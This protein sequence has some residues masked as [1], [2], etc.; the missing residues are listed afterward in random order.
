MRQGRQGIT[1]REPR[2]RVLVVDD[3][4]G[5]RSLL[6]S[7]LEAA[8]LDVVEADDGGRAVAAVN[9]SRPG[10]VILDVDLPGLSGYEVCHQLRA[11][12]ATL[13][14]LLLSGERVESYDRVAGLLLGADD[15]M[16]KPFAID[17]FLARARRMVAR[18]SGSDN[19]LTPREIEVLVLLA[20]GS[21][22]NAIA[23]ELV[24]TPKTAAKHIE[25]I[26]SKL[27]LHSRASAVTWAFEHGL[28]EPG[29]ASATM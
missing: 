7:V 19:P 16:Q 23:S 12:F 24:I 1:E 27:N 22:Q 21:S 11:K 8:G 28:V 4:P 20:Q 17:E 2:S 25:R 5:L 15:F 29:N 6:V 9:E 3:D 10:L 18:S 26:L 13:P 14:I